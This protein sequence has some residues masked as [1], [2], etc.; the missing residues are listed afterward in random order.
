M[1]IGV[2]SIYYIFMIFRYK[3]LFVVSHPATK[4]TLQSFV[5][6]EHVELYIDILPAVEYILYAYFIEILIYP[7]QK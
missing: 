7:Q 4:I 5:C 2:K 6:K 3:M 1:F